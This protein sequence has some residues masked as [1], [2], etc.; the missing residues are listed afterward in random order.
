[1]SAGDAEYVSVCI[2]VVGSGRGE[3]SSYT[4]HNGQTSQ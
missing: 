3:E 1:M 4:A 2:M